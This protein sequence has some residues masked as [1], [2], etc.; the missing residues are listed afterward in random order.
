V[1]DLDLPQSRV[2][3]GPLAELKDIMNADYRTAPA[4][5]APETVRFLVHILSTSVNLR[6]P[7]WKK[8][9]CHQDFRVRMPDFDGYEISVHAAPYTRGTGR[10]LWGF[11]SDMRRKP[12]GYFLMFLNTAH[13]PG[14]IAATVAHELG[15]YIHQSTFSDTGLSVSDLSGT[16]AAH[17]S[18]EAE[19]FYDSLVALSA[20]NSATM[21]KVRPQ[22]NT[23]PDAKTWSAEITQA[24][25]LIYRD[26]RIDFSRRRVSLGWRVRYLAATLHSFKLRRVLLETAGV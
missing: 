17:L 5:P 8:W 11:S 23:S 6:S 25:D 14:A 10:S 1:G 20:Y 18:D 4:L 7:D 22:R 24:C 16:F 26:F 3:E 12:G 19:L 15:H 21:Q 13:E 2:S 9:R